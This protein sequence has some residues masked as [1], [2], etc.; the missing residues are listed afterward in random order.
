MVSKINLSLFSEGPIEHLEKG[1]A[2]MPFVG[3]KAHYWIENKGTMTPTISGG[4]RVRFYTSRCG[5]TAE[6]DS[7]APALGAGNFPKCQRCIRRV[8]ANS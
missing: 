5:V 2:L 8:N 6:T 3:G 4:G 1:W 7:R